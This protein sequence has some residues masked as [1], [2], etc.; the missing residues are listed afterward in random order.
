MQNV[1]PREG[2]SAAISDR[3]AK[4]GV[5]TKVRVRVGRWAEDNVNGAAH[6]H[7]T[8]GIDLAALVEFGVE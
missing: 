7:V 2:W 1:R 3:R 5:K 6:V 8:R 4:R